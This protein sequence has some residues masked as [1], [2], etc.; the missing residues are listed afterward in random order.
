MGWKATKAIER[1]AHDVTDVSRRSRTHAAHRDSVRPESTHCR[2][3]GLAR[4]GPLRAPNLTNLMPTKRTPP[5]SS[6][7]VPL[8]TLCPQ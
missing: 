4:S 5:L 7:P 2:G 1:W 8:E 6:G 3:N